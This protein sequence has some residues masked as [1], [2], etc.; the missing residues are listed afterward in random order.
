MVISKK[1]KIIE[2]VVGVIALAIFAVLFITAYDAYHNETNNRTALV[3]METPAAADYVTASARVLSVDPI[4]GEMAVRISFTPEG[5]LANAGELKNELALYVNSAT[6]GQ[7][8]SFPKGKDMSPIDVTLDMDGTVTDYPFDHH[9]AFL[10][11]YLTQPVKDGEPLAIPIATSFTGSVSGMKV[12]A[13]LNAASADNYN[14]IDITV[15]RSQAI[16]TL[17]IFAM[18][19][20]WLITLTVVLM[21]LAVVLR[22]R[23]V[24]FGMFA[25]MAGFL[26]SFVAFRN[27]MPG[28]PPIGTLSDYLAFF[29]GYA[30]ISLSLIGLTLTWLIRPAK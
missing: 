13:S 18:G 12:G 1:R 5:S 11:L 14:L 28:V 16:L 25:F 27:A 22:G 15:E 7:N 29:W 3:S 21:L 2:A 6:G 4:K 30:L 10:E 9:E 17:V 20:L 23:K 24:E 26:F 19:L 8:R